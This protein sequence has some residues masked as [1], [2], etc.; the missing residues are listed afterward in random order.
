MTAREKRMLD[1][2]KNIVED[3]MD[4][5]EAGAYVASPVDGL[6]EDA[7]M[8]LNLDGTFNTTERAILKALKYRINANGDEATKTY[9]KVPVLVVKNGY[10]FYSIQLGKSKRNYH[11]IDLDDLHEAGGPDLEAIYQDYING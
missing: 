1:S 10:N 3:M 7:Y 9:K 5:K 8:T 4:E 2:I 11:F 6:I